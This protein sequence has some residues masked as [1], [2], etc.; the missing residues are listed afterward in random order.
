MHRFVV[1]LTCFLVNE[2]GPNTLDLYARSR[3]LLDV[4]DEHTLGTRHDQKLK[5]WSPW[6]HRRAN[7]LCPHI[8]ISDRLQSD[9]NFLFWPFSL[10]RHASEQMLYSPGNWRT[11][12]RPF[13]SSTREP[14]SIEMRSFT[15]DI[16]LW[17]ISFVVAEI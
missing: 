11:F 1:F 4:L 14:I 9:R 16:A 5:T 7:N 6:T 2:S 17:R 10:E 13:L 15:L 3:F 12:S 8:E